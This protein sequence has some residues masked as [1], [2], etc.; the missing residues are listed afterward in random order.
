M[1]DTAATI[2]HYHVVAGLSEG[3]N[4]ATLD[5]ARDLAAAQA[6]SGLTVRVW[7]VTTDGEMI[8]A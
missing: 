3:V 1:S 2:R 7:A 8:A 6:A 5:E 4:F